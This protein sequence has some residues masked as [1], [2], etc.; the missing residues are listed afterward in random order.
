MKYLLLVVSSFLA[1]ALQMIA[2]DIFFLFKFLN[3]SLILVAWWTIYYS[4]VRALFFGSFTGLLVDYALGWPLGYNG[5]GLTLAVFI[6]GQSWDRFNTGEQPTVR[7]LI[8]AASS[9]ASSLSIFFLFWITQ[10][11]TSRIFLGS[12]VLQALI[13]AG[14]G[15]IFF[16][17]LERYKSTQAHKAH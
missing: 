1:V 15:F 12:A 2:S 9:L 11:A 4:R 14:A 6:I 10:R 7:F 16:I 8:L 5:F 3:I 13:T 17:V